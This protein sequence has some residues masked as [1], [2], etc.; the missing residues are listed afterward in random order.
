MGECLAIKPT[1]QPDIF[2]YMQANR[3]I[4]ISFVDD[5]VHQNQNG[6]FVVESTS[7]RKFFNIKEIGFRT[8]AVSYL[9][10]PEV[11]IH[12]SAEVH[13][14]EAP[15]MQCLGHFSKDAYK[16]VPVAWVNDAEEQKVG[17]E[18]KGAEEAKEEVF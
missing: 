11:T 16:K 4:P 2:M 6:L 14:I 9:H 15:E 7:M 5:K 13:Q 18:E 8:V 12:R 3:I 1:D 10:N 17:E